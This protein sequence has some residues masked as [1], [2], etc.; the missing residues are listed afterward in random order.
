M[1]LSSQAP[2]TACTLALLLGVAAVA[3]QEPSQA[4]V[5]CAGGAG[6]GAA[7]AATLQRRWAP[8]LAGSSGWPVVTKRSGAA[9]FLVLARHLKPAE[10][11]VEF[12][13]VGK[14][15][16]RGWPCPVVRGRARVG[17]PAPHPLHRLSV[18]IPRCAAPLQPFS[19]H[20]LACY[21]V[22]DTAP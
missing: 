17:R 19:G 4:G 13:Q 7:H 3:A 15:A 11:N 22:Y 1:P 20:H 16:S 21:P 2:L 18:Q 8:Q 12:A 14:G 10:A 6:C 5:L 9:S